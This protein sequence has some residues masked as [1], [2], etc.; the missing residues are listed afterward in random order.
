MEESETMSLT[1]KDGKKLIADF[2]SENFTWGQKAPSRLDLLKYSVT[3]AFNDGLFLEF[4]VLGGYS[5]KYLAECRPDRRFY[6][7]DTFEGIPENWGEFYPKGHG[8]QDHI[9]QIPGD[10][11]LIKGLFQ[12]TLEP[13]LEE[14]SEPVSF[15]HMDADLY[16]STNYVLSTLANAGRIVKGTI[17]EF[18]EVFFQ[19]SHNTVLNDEYRAYLEFME[20][21][22][23]KVRWLQFYHRKTSYIWKKMFRWTKRVATIR[24]SLV[25]ESF[26]KRR[27]KV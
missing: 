20:R 23:V 5:L 15:L 9:P 13:F 11:I 6:G 24:A 4:G 25:I 27:V 12:D 3:Q 14:H 22:E 17:I 8:K 18:D 19:D 2:L 1:L 26:Q 21:Y 10:I 16:S 7:F